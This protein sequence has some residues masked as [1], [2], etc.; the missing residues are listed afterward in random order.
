MS[1]Q[2]TQPMPP[3]LNHIVGQR[4]AVEQA[5]VALDCSFQEGTAFPHMLM[6]GPPGVGKTMLCKV[7]AA[8]MASP[9]LEVLGQSLA[10]PLELHALLLTATDKSIVFIDECDGIPNEQIQ[11][12]LYRAVEE[13]VLHL[14]P[15]QPGR[16][17]QKLPLADFTLVL[18]SNNEFS[19]V[20][21]LRDRMK[22]T[23][24]FDYYTTDELIE[25][26]KQRAR[27]LAWQVA[28]EVIPMI[29]AR[30]RGTPR[31][32]LRLLEACRRVCRS[33]GETTIRRAD[34]ERACA[35][36][37]LDTRGLDRQEVAL[38]R[39][40]DDARGS[41]RLNVIATRLGLPA[42]TITSVFESYL[43]REGLIERVPEGRRITAL[44]HQHLHS[45][46]S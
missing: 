29:A 25:V 38:L 1:D 40:L 33:S 35:L 5:K 8:E 37:G 7:I 18:A 32:A 24:R 43:L 6:T 30:G 21:P 13:R 10:G 41:L 44:G 16:P 45:S 27:G 4:L 34:F 11:V 15:S 19:I 28:R 14:P 46:E 12:A 36:E 26:I 20:A 22:L 31:I 42:R 3:T 39:M 9:L 2:I 23:L 17:P